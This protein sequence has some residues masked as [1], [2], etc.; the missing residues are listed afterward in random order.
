MY[1]YAHT[2]PAVHQ[3]LSIGHRGSDLGVENTLKAVEGAIESGADYAEVDIQLT[4]DLVPV[5][6]HDDSLSRMA[7]QSDS[8]NELTLKELQSIPLSQYGMI[9]FLQ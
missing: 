6:A 3:P 4:K 5:A 1:Q 9:L 8:I 2:P 7:G